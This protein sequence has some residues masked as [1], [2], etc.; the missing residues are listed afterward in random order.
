[1]FDVASADFEWQVADTYAVHSAVVCVV[2]CLYG[3]WWT[4]EWNLPEWCMSFGARA[5]LERRRAI[6]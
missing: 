5:V 6:L 4:R 2:L 1:M 3:D